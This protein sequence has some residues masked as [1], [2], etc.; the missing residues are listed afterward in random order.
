MLF[1]NAGF[2]EPRQYRYWNAE[3][4][5]L[6]LDG[7]LEDLRAAPKDS[8]IILHACAHNPTGC[9]PTHEQWAQIADVIQ[10]KQL[11]PFFDS[12]YQGFASGDPVKDAWAVR[13]FTDRGFELLCAQSFAKNFG[14]Y[15]KNLIFF[16]LGNVK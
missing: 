12:A 6:D 15:S 5:S 1:T 8:V 7:F 4:R 16:C 11:F 3:T 9:D 13:Y 2:T 14:L 10:E